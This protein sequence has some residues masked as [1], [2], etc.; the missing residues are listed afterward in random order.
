[1]TLCWLVQF[2]ETLKQEAGVRRLLLLH[3]CNLHLCNNFKESHRRLVESFATTA[4]PVDVATFAGAADWRAHRPDA[5]SQTAATRTLEPLPEL[6][7]MRQPNSVS[8]SSVPIGTKTTNNRLA[9]PGG[10]SG[11]DQRRWDWQDFPDPNWL[12]VLHGRCTTCWMMYATI[13]TM[14]HSQLCRLIDSV[15]S[16]YFGVR[17]NCILMGRLVSHSSIGERSSLIFSSFHLVW[18]S[19]QAFGQ[20]H[21]QL[22]IM[23]FLLHTS[24]DL[25]RFYRLL[26]EEQQQQQELGGGDHFE[27]HRQQHELDRVGARRSLARAT[28]DRP[29]S[30]SAKMAADPNERLLRHTLCYQVRLDG[31]LY[32]RLRPN[33]TPEARPKLVKSLVDS[34]VV[35]LAMLLSMSVVLGSYTALVIMSDRRYASIYPG[36]SE[37]LD[38]MFARGELPYFSFYPTPHHFIS[39]AVDGLENYCIW[40]EGGLSIFFGP[41]LCYLLNYDMLLYWSSL[42]TKLQLLLRKTRL[43]SAFYNWPVVATATER[44]A[45]YCDVPTNKDESATKGRSPGWRRLRAEINELQFEMLDFFHELERTDSLLSDVLTAAIVIWLGACAMI[46]YNC[47]TNVRGRVPNVVRFILTVTLML[48]TAGTYYLL[49]LRRGCLRGYKTLCSLM[50]HEQTGQKRCFIKIMDFFNEMNRT[51]YTLAHHYPYKPTTFITILGYTLSCF[52]IAISLFGN[53][54]DQLGVLSGQDSNLARAQNIIDRLLSELV[55]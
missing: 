45:N 55:D 28:T 19:L 11:G 1:M 54:R 23:H 17:G 20:R 25:E 7:R 37:W 44:T 36:C 6:V 39:G 32:F 33:R 21:Y 41:A 48:I 10:G 49:L 3:L 5:T 16:P 51:T 18:R 40:V 26:G 52:F 31:R 24:A 22:S 9:G 14:F 12:H 46:G 38:R 53:R 2:Y 30:S 27:W 43:R 15:S 34:F 4:S 8:S 42:E 50:A 13:R 29:A 35:A 47:L